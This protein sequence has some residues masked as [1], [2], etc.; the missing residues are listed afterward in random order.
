MAK[1]VTLDK[2]IATTRNHSLQ[3]S[4]LTLPSVLSDTRPV[5]VNT[6]VYK[7]SFR[8]SYATPPCRVL[9]AATNA[10]LTDYQITFSSTGRKPRSHSPSY[11]ASIIHISVRLCEVKG[12]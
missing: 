8:H 2:W 9:L 7:S 3:D 4:I 6:Y 5:V 12:K 10:P 11:S 1:C